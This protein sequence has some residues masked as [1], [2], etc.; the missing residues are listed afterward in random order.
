MLTQK[1]KNVDLGTGRQEMIRRKACAAV[2]K[3]MHLL[4]IELN[5]RK[6]TLEHSVAHSIAKR[7]AIA[8][9]QSEVAME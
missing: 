1:A 8:A 4:A 2:D 9:I 3:A 7:R 6:H 5:L